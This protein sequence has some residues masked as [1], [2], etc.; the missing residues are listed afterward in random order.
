MITIV[1][2]LLIADQ[3]PSADEVKNTT[4]RFYLER[5][6]DV[7]GVSGVGVVA[8]GVEFPSGYCVLEWQT[9]TATTEFAPN[10][11]NIITVHGH[12]GKTQV[13]FIDNTNIERD[14]DFER[15]GAFRP[16]EPSEKYSPENSDEPVNIENYHAPT[17]SRENPIDLIP[18]PNAITP[19]NLGVTPPLSNEPSEDSPNSLEEVLAGFNNSFESLLQFIS[20]NKESYE[21]FKAKANN[22]NP[23]DNPNANA[24][25]T[26]PASPAADPNKENISKEKEEEEKEKEKKEEKELQPAF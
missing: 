1:D 17:I 13:V 23:L 16:L 24:V 20:A 10:I 11:D 7:S 18:S 2:R 22:P 19:S 6:V 9:E 4:R 8:V 21:K 26:P 15:K 3:L 14:I 5:L 25:T 12:D